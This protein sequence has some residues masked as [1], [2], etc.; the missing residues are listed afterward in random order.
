MAL[1]AQEHS[2]AQLPVSIYW[3]LPICESAQ[4][5]PLFKNFIVLHC[6]KGD[7]SSHQSCEYSAWLKVH[8]MITCCC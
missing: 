4:P 2:W 8:F 6:L 1:E 5:T 7:L 3:K